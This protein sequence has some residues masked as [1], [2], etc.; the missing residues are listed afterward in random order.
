[1]QKV[2]TIHFLVLISLLAGGSVFAA[3]MDP[4]MD[5][6]EGSPMEEMVLDQG[7]QEN[8]LTEGAQASLGSTAVVMIQGTSEDSTVKGTMNLMEVEGGLKIEA[9]LHGA[10]PGKHGFHIHEKGNCE[11]AGKAA[12]GHYNPAG[13]KHGFLAEEGFENA[14]G[15]DLGNVEIDEKGDGQVSLVLPGLGLTSGQY[16]VAGLA[17][18]LHENQDDGGQPTGNAGGRIGCGIIALAQ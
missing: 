6:S 3:P 14:H 8:S 4:S 11:E 2:F 15:G 10:P 13:V 1:M 16:P 17:V 12:G 7:S 5:S 9:E 18:I